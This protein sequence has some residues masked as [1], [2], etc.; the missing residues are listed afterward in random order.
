MQLITLKDEGHQIIMTIKYLTTLPLQPLSAYNVILFILWLQV[1]SRSENMLNRPCIGLCLSIQLAQNLYTLQR[2]GGHCGRQTSRMYHEIR[3]IIQLY[4]KWATLY[5]RLSYHN[6]LLWSL[7]ITTILNWCTEIQMFWWVCML[8]T[9]AVWSVLLYAMTVLGKYRS[10]WFGLLIDKRKL[11][12][13]LIGI[14]FQWR[15]IIREALNS[16]SHQFTSRL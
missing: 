15:W 5:C 6:S 14:R 3:G 4:T 2:A 9:V 11:V 7:S 13:Q 10:L 16:L 1:Y 8:Q 12:N